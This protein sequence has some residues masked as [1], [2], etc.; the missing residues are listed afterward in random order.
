[1]IT[2]QS[3]KPEWTGR[4]VDYDHVYAY[5]CVDEILEWC[6]ENGIP[7]GVWGNAIDYATHPTPTFMA[8]FSPVTSYQPGDVVVLYGL[9]GNPYG[10][11]GLFDH[12][13]AS[14][15]WILEQ[16]RLGDGTGLGGSAIGVYRSIPLSRVAKVWRLNAPVPTPAPAPAR[17]TVTLPRGVGTWHFYNYG[18]SYNPN[19]PKAVKGVL[20]PDLFGP[21]TYKIES[22]VGDYAVVITTQDYGRGVIWVK[23]TPAVI[24]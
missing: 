19:D 17:S 20:R 4:R 21:L 5:Q 22:W 11:I 8:H 10:H 3:F 6:A 13:D 23:G 14:G 24:N 9:P 12:Q 16:N 1:M 18:S 7:T 15:I 2:Y